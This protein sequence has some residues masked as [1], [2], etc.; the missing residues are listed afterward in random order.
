[1]HVGCILSVIVY[2]S[3]RSVVLYNIPYAQAAAA[4]QESWDTMDEAQW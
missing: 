4:A 1:M 2:E 3:S